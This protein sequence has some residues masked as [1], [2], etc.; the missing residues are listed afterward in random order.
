VIHASAPSPIGSHVDLNKYLDKH[1]VVAEL[2]ATNAR[3]EMTLEHMKENHVRELEQLR[4]DLE[5]RIKE[6]QDSNAMFGQGIS[7]LMQK[8]GVAD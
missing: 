3:L 2:K 7:M 4:K 8:M 1:E 6:A 5:S